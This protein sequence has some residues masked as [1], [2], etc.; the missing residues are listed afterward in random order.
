MTFGRNTRNT[1]PSVQAERTLKYKYIHV[2]M[3]YTVDNYLQ[4][5]FT[6]FESSSGPRAPCDVRV[7]LRGYPDKMSSSEGGGCHGKGDI[8]SKGGC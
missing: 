6:A 5:F 3:L 2:C 8:D 1:H 4:L 7:G